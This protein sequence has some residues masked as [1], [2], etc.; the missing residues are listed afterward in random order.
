MSELL[1]TDDELEVSVLVLV[2]VL[3]ATVDAESP[4][5]ARV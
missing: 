4:L 5:L 3:D 2:L 1:E